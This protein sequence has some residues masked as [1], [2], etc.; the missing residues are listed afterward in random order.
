[1]KKHLL[2]I[3]FCLFLPLPFTVKA[4]SPLIDSLLAELDKKHPDTTRLKILNSLTRAYMFIEPEE[5][6]PFA[7]DAI[8]LAEKTKD[9]ANIATAYINLGGLNYK[10][11]E[12]RAAFDLYFEALQIREEINDI[13]G[14][15][16]L[17]NNLGNIKHNQGHY[18]AAMEYYKKCLNVSLQF[19]DKLNMSRAQNN[20]AALF[21]IEEEY[22]KAIKA[23]KEVMKL[24]IELND[25][26]GLSNS[27]HNLG[28]SYRAYADYDS[29]L[30]YLYKEMELIEKANLPHLRISNY[31]ELAKTH[32]VKGNFQRSVD[33]GKKALELAY[34]SKS[35]FEILECVRFMYMMHEKYK[36]FE[37]AFEYLKLT[38]AY[39]D[40]IYGEKNNKEIL[41]L[42]AKYENTKK[43]KENALLKAE[44]EEQ[45][46]LLARTNNI[47]IVIAAILCLICCIAYFLYKS[48]TKQKKIKELL[49]KK[50]KEIENKNKILTAQSEQL[51]QQKA[52]L[53]EL[54]LVKDKVFSIIGHDLRGPMASL[55]SLF[56]LIEEGVDLHS[57]KKTLP[58]L[59]KDLNNT[60]ELLDNLLYWA[61]G[62]MHGLKVKYGYINVTEIA[63]E[64]LSLV[65]SSA[66]RKKLNLKSEI[67]DDVLMYADREM[68]QLIVRNIMFNAIKFTPENGNITLKAWTDK[69]LSYI[70]INDTGVGI[71]PEDQQ[72]IFSLH[73]STR[74]TSN[75]KGTG[76]GLILCKEFSLKNGGDI[77]LESTPGK[78]S[79]FII[80]IPAREPDFKNS[81]VQAS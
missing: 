61:K 71:N 47:I 73:K 28:V 52:E 62:Q 24:K 42:E 4:H 36:D 30:F 80:A 1:M 44:K 17:Y 19:N 13:A 5:G 8:E 26:P 77:W 12:F 3:L 51:R 56:Y 78:G 66:S 38:N 31:R 76:L 7:K 6:I 64:I 33:F 53:E 39:S 21:W 60:S 20:M 10:R 22:E 35:K 63:E 67:N 75:E 27:Y 14:T 68:I 34:A 15:A 23:Y 49:Q 59:Q 11:G 48:R 29:S 65:K 54:N 25:L 81:E 40:S 69:D 50:N 45:E 18:D 32:N 37:K 46:A 79:T 43:E 72:K 2:F 16:M 58:D 41:E 74:G 55:S 70:S 9:K 57:L